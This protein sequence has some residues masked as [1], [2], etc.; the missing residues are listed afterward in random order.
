MKRRTFLGAASL[1]AAASVAPH[2]ARGAKPRVAIVGGGF[3]GSACA[4]ALRRADPSLDVTLIDPVARYVTCPMSNEVVVGARALDS[5][6]ITRDALA[7]AGVRFVRARATALDAD[8]RTL[9]LDDGVHVPFDVCVVAP[10]IRFLFG[11]PEGYDE[12]ASQQMPHAWEAGAQTT[13][14]AALLRAMDDGGTFAISVPAGLMRCPPGPYERASLVAEF[15]A[16]HKP[17]S[18]VLIFDANNRFPRQE[19][20]TA[21]WKDLYGDRIEWI[22]VT[23]GGAVERVDVRTSTLHTSSGAHRVAVANVIPPQAPGAFALDAGLASGRGWC[24]VDPATFESANVP[25]VHVIGDAC[26]ADAMPKAASAALSQAKQCAAAILA[27]FGNGNAPTPALDSVCYSALALD[28]SL[29]IHARF[30]VEHGHVVAES[31]SDD[32]PPAVSAAERAAA[33]TWYRAIRRS[34]F[35]V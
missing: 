10:G 12:A 28:R 24:P 16:K 29:A 21:A 15:L 31:A 23:E 5:L 26:I 3:G 9:R 27:R 7:R 6:A 30:R 1:V 14:L 33:I 25:R 22:P 19:A 2:I 11:A 18:K 32:S 8:A 35:G 17:R 20:F 34:A 4:L 13:R